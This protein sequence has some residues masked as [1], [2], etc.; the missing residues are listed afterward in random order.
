MVATT[1]D[2]RARRWYHHFLGAHIVHREGREQ[3]GR[4]P[5]GVGD[6]WQLAGL[7]DVTLKVV[8]GFDLIGDPVQ[9]GD[10]FYLGFDGSVLGSIDACRQP[11]GERTLHAMYPLH[12]GKADSS[13]Y[14][15]ATFLGAIA[16]V[17]SEADR[18]FPTPFSSA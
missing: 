8:G 12:A 17:V 18:A 9:P 13:L 14:K 16:L 1:A 3:I 5:Q 6:P 11:A 10:A 4:L 2:L 15:F 7:V